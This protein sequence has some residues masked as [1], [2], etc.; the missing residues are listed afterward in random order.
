M[1]YSAQPMDNRALVE[2]YPIGREKEAGEL[3]RADLDRFPKNARSERGLVD[4]GGAR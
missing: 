4:A 1:R 2:R 3:F